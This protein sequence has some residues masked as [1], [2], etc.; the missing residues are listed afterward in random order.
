MKTLLKL[1]SL[2]L[3]LFLF[4]GC[5]HNYYNIPRESYE[6]KVRVLGVAPIFLDAES[7]IRI[8]DREPL[9]AL[10]RDLNRKNEPELVA[11]LKETGAYL[12]VRMPDA[13][14]DELFSSLVFRRE[15]RSDAGVLYNKHFYKQREVKEFIEKN[16]LDAVMLVVVSGLTR[17][18][19]LYSSNLLSFLE[20]NYNFII[21]TAQIVDSDGNV[22]WEFPN[23]QQRLR[24]LTPLINLQY[25]DF[26]EAAA[27]V[28]ELVDV[29]FKTVPGISRAFAKPA[30]STVLREA[31]VSKLYEQ[32]FDEMVAMLKPP[33]RWFWE[34]A[35]PEPKRE[36]EG[37]PVARP[38][39]REPSAPAKAAPAPRV[40]PEQA[41]PAPLQVEQ[42]KAPQQAPAAADPAPVAAGG[43]RVETLTPVR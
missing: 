30:S 8:P 4:S 16:S 20:Y 3:A 1:V 24:P 5:A 22:L 23:F 35:K 43:V 40:E 41:K 38:M 34:D 39:E 37:K 17:P 28:T 29:K 11:R 18:D 19:K 6:K 9:L 15:R 21:L 12:S 42:P 27:N 13:S 14:A 2:S 10:L 31:R 36:S 7:D 25:A 32:V 33:F 26:D